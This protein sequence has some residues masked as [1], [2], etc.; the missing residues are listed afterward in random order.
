VE[1]KLAKVGTA[2]I[3]CFGGGSEDVTME[4]VGAGEAEMLFLMAVVLVVLVGLTLRA[5]GGG[6]WR[7]V[8]R[9]VLS[10]QQPE[11][12]ISEEEDV[13]QR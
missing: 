5:L 12:T 9:M 7:L 2:D 3:L 8:T 10:L 4:R 11:V 13:V 6:C 1:V